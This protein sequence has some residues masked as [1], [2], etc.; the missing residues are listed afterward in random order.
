MAILLG[1]L[2]LHGLQPG[3]EMLRDHLDLVYALLFGIILAQVLTSALGLAA[4]PW[5]ARLSLLPNRWIAPFVLVLVFVGTYMVRTNILDVG[6]AITAGVFGYLMRRYGFPLITIA[7]G[8]ILG[9]LAER[10][11]IQSMQISDGD[12]AIFVTRPIALALLSLAMLSFAAPM[13]AAF[14]SN[15]RRRVTA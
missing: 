6:M 2:I 5:I 13:I 4:T 11:Y 9:P 8:F 12:L 15:H 7:I 14:H 1:A 3:P 10:S